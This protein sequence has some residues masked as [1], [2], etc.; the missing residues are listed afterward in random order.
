MNKLLNDPNEMSF[1]DHLEDF[2]F[3]GHIAPALRVDERE[4]L[5]S[6]NVRT[7]NGVRSTNNIDTREG[8]EG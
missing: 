5:R 4:P 2:F 8:K 7:S 6:A 3:V 1:L